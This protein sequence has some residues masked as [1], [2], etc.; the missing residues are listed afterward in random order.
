MGLFCDVVY[1]L[2]AGDADARDRATALF[3]DPAKDTSARDSLDGWLAGPID[4]RVA[5]AE[6]SFGRFLMAADVDGES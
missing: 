5:D 2:L 1:A 3:F 6:K 4:P